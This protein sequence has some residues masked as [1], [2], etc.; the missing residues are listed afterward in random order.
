MDKPVFFSL[1]PALLV[2]FF[3]LSLSSA[4]AEEDQTLRVLLTRPALTDR[5][6]LS[7]DGSY[8]I[9]SIAFQRGST[10]TVSCS[11]GR[12]MVYYD[13]MAFEHGTSLLLLRH[14]LP[15][16]EQNE[17]GLRINH[18]YPLHPGD[19]LLTIKNNA[20]RAILY[21]NV[22]EYLLGVIPYE[23]SDSYPLEALKA[24]AI[25]SRTYAL[26]RKALKNPDYDVTDNP[27][28]QVYMGIQKEHFRSAKAVNETAGICGINADGTYAS[29]YYCASNGGQTETVSQVWGGKDLPYLVRQQD[30]YD[31]EN[32]YS[33]VRS[34]SVPKSVAESGV[35]DPLVLPR[36]RDILAKKGIEPENF[37]WSTVDSLTL[38]NPIP[39]N[40]LRF[41]EM[42]MEVSVEYTVTDPEEEVYYDPAAKSA[43]SSAPAVQTQR[44]LSLSLSLP[45]F[46]DL[47][48]A[49]DLLINPGSGNELLTVEE[50][51]TSFV[52][53]S[54]RYG[55]GVGMSQRGAQWMALKYGKTADEILQFYYPGLQFVRKAP[56]AV[57]PAATV[58]DRTF[59]A[60]PGPAASPTPRPTLMPTDLVRGEGIR[61]VSVTGIS[62]NSYLNMRVSPSITSPVVCP[63]YYGQLLAVVEETVDGWLHVKTD[64]MDGYVYASYVE[65]LPEDLSSTIR[66][67]SST[68]SK[69]LSPSRGSST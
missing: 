59:L 17:N 10:L 54:R 29:C 26:N 58:L 36:I 6:D 64:V 1:F 9:D 25:A 46:P 30:P 62:E 51:E 7:L 19:L 5:V 33:T 68:G 13:G 55:H 3:T 43:P 34:F 8:S 45:V 40:S 57:F 52:L 4:A 20:L 18:A 47:V 39:L 69:R 37:R 24:Q 35:L 50:T 11:S 65:P 23:M 44:S 49:C 56:G 63:L 38:K 32:P 12:L 48:S 22:E 16:S 66:S 60:T 53:K 27:N 15:D 42:A 61:M 2:L 31:P 41:T 67:F 14:P 21:V 28:D